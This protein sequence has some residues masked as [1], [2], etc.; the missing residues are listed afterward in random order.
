M[1]ENKINEILDSEKADSPEGWYILDFF[2]KTFPKDN[3]FFDDFETYMQKTMYDSY[4]KKLAFIILGLVSYFDNSEIYL[5]AYT[6]YDDPKLNSLVHKDLLDEL[7]FDE[8]GNLIIE[9]VK[10]DTG[11][12]KIALVDNNNHLAIVDIS[13]GTRISFYNLSSEQKS[14]ASDLITAQGFYLKKARN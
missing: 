5:D 11:F 12:L 14:L 3:F 6:E 7:S 8:I 10:N 9:T 2:P 13:G 4:S 1:W